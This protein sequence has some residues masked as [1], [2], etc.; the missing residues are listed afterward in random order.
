MSGQYATDD[1]S[2]GYKYG[3]LM[4]QQ[5]SGQGQNVQPGSSQQV[6]PQGFGTAQDVSNNQSTGGSGGGWGG[7]TGTASGAWGGANQWQ[8]S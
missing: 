1:K 7:A 3:G 6:Q 8:G 5:Q 2:Q 4:G